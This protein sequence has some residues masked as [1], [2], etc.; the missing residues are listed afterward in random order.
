VKFRPIYFEKTKKGIGALLQ[1]IAKQK[2]YEILFDVTEN[3]RNSASNNFPSQIRNQ[4]SVMNH[5]KTKSERNFVSTKQKTGEIPFGMST[6]KKE[7]L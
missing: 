1:I 6:W 2:V 4:N 3:R 5:C 7:K